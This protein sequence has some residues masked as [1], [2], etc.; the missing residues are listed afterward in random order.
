MRDA[1]LSIAAHELKTPVTAI[2]GYAQVLQRRAAYEQGEGRRHGR[3]AQVIAEQAERLAKLVGSLLEVSRLETG[4]FTLDCQLLDLGTLVRRVVDEVALTLPQGSMH[5]LTCSGAEDGVQVV[6]DALRLEQ[7]L[8][9]LL[10][11]AI[12]YSPAGG[13]VSVRVARHDDQAVVAVRDQGI[14]IPR[15]AQANVFQRF[16]RAGNIRSDHISGLGI[17]LYIVQEIVSRHGGTVDVASV[18]GEGSTFTVRLP[19]AV[20]APRGTQGTT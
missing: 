10:Q 17:G 20:P 2:L 3:A 7:V 16:Y 12:K 14:G 11:N 1:F 6:G 19:L 8:H 5:T 18:D 4:Q 15:D 9:N 13:A